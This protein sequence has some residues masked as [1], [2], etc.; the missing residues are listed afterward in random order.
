[1]VYYAKSYGCDVAVDVPSGRIFSEDFF[2]KMAFWFDDHGDLG[3]Y[4]L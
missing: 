2:R 4:I 1:M 3:Y